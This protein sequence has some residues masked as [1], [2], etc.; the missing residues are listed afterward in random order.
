VDLRPV[1]AQELS[2]SAKEK[3]RKRRRRRREGWGLY[4]IRLVAPSRLA[5]QPCHTTCGGMVSSGPTN[6]MLATT[7]VAGL[8]RRMQQRDSVVLPHHSERDSVVLPRHSAQRDQKSHAMKIKSWMD[9][10]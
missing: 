4:Y 2:G 1:A 8:S 6:A 9:Y 5:R 3:E 10:F 7:S